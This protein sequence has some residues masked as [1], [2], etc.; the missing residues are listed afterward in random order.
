MAQVISENSITLSPTR[1]RFLTVAAAGATALALPP[2]TAAAPAVDPI[3]NLIEAHRKAHAAHMASL[4]LQNR[5]KTLSR[6]KRGLRSV[7]CR[8]RYHAA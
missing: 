2:S 4:E 8:A 5:N 7:H 3:I 1:R 6:R